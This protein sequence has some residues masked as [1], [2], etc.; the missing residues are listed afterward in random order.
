MLGA[1]IEAR[2][3]G[4]GAIRSSSV[5]LVMR[6][7]GGVSQPRLGPGGPPPRQT[8]ERVG[9]SQPV[10]HVRAAAVKTCFL[11]LIIV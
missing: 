2:L 1:G 7:G 9:S 5:V 10:F 6:E 8:S 11:C 3:A 4:G